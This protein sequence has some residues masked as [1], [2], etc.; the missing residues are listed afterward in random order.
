V[1]YVVRNITYTW[2]QELLARVMIADSPEVI[3]STIELALED[4]GVLSFIRPK[5]GRTSS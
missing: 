3:H 4:A 5:G 1:K 2:S